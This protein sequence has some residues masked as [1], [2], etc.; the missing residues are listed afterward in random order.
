M[1]STDL[2]IEETPP[3]THRCCCSSPM[4]MDF[5]TSPFVV[6]NGRSE[7]ATRCW[8]SAVQNEWHSRKWRTGN[9]SPNLSHPVTSYTVPYFWAHSRCTSLSSSGGV[10]A[11]FKSS[12]F[13]I[14]YVN[15]RIS[16]TVFRPRGERYAEPPHRMQIEKKTAY[17]EAIER[18]SGIPLRKHAISMKFR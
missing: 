13:H 6:Q 17:D 5:T 14:Q 15:A 1:T 16:P 3:G 18:R 8:W 12:A 2:E 11:E 4:R 10:V 9:C 7:L